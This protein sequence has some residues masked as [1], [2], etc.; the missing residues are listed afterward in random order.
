MHAVQVRNV[1]DQL[2]QKLKAQSSGHHRSLSGEILYI[3]EKHL[4]SYDN[5]RE[6][7]WSGIVS[8]HEKI[9]QTYG[10]AESSVAS[11]RED[12]DR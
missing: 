7:I 1:P 6:D 5:S 4:L 9:K 11:I 10:V 2:Y 12:R 3:L 8:V